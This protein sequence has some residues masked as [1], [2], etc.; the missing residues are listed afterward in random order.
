MIEV[1]Q[2]SQLILSLSLLIT[3]L[4]RDFS[5]ATIIMVLLFVTLYFVK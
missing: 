2:I 1:L 5:I 4:K 3:A